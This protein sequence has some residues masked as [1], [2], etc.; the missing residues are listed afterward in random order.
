MHFVL[1][2]TMLLLMIVEGAL[3]ISQAHWKYMTLLTFLQNC[4][5]PIVYINLN[6]MNTKRTLEAVKQLLFLFTQIMITGADYW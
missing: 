4:N 3:Q 6:T 5:L 1:L 2:T